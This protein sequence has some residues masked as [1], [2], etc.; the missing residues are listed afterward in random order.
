V[1]VEDEGVG[2]RGALAWMSVW[3]R[4]EGDGGRVKVGWAICGGEDSG[5][6]VFWRCVV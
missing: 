6:L 1:L 3:E 4:R 2:G 5:S